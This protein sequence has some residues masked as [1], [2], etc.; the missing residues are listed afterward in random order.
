MMQILRGRAGDPGVWWP[1]TASP[2]LACFVAC[3]VCGQLIGLRLDVI[4]P[5][6][7]VGQE[8]ACPR[9]GCAWSEYV[10]LADWPGPRE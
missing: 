2:R 8:L 9:E 10:I 3:P 5:S 1:T 4:E 7:R 6:G